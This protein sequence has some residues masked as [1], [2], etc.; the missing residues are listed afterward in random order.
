MSG[1]IN[2]SGLSGLVTVLAVGGIGALFLVTH[3]RRRSRRGQVGKQDRS[4]R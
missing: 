2:G 3:G 4:E 1:A